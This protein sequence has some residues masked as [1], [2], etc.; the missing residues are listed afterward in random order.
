MSRKKQMVLFLTVLT[1][2]LGMIFIAISC[3][4][5]P[6]N[7]DFDN[8]PVSMKIKSPAATVY[9]LYQLTVS[10]PDIPEPIVIPLM[11]QDGYLI[12]PSATQEGEGELD[13]PAGRDRLFTVEVI[14]EIISDNGTI[15]V[16]V[17]RGS[18]TANVLPDAPVVVNL[19]IRPVVPMIRISPRIQTVNPLTTFSVKVQAYNMPLL[20]GASFYISWDQ[21]DI[22]PDSA[23]VGGGLN[24]SNI[25]FSYDD[26][27]G[28]GYTVEINQTADGLNLLGADGAGDLAEIFLTAH[29]YNPDTVFTTAID[30]DVRTLAGAG[31]N[32]VYINDYYYDNADVI[33]DFNIPD[34]RVVT[35]ADAALEAHI[36][37]DINKPIGDLYLSDVFPITSVYRVEHN[38]VNL[39]GISN[40][41]NLSYLELAGS[42]D[43]GLADISGIE[44]LRKIT[45]CN[46]GGNNITN[47]QPLSGLTTI[48][49]LGLN[50]NNIYNL[51]AL[52]GLTNIVT[53]YLEG[54]NIVDIQ[55][56]VDNP[57]LASGDYLYL[58]GN[59]LNAD[60]YD[61]HIPALEARGVTVYTGVK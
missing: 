19:V 41:V 53:L 28:V 33:V 52:T 29:F 31:D 37:S 36:R 48:G 20:Y 43:N 22:D 30:L 47:I 2:M 50:Y 60:A 32:P 39:S 7:S 40:L 21:S 58:S 11:L 49:F 23:R 61:F 26:N 6:V 34:D 45:H 3:S 51:N 4:K 10:A 54:N 17:Y 55:P 15:L 18:A 24:G 42:G 25:D 56:L 35:F 1:V 44:G 12:I 14:D 16:V 57:G 38:I 8:V 5:K 46:L 13:V 59:P 27:D 9:D